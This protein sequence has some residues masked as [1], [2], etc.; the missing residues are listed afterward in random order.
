[1]PTTGT[2]GP[3]VARVDHFGMSVPDVDAAARFFETWF[4]ATVAFR[5]PWIEG[6]EAV[7]RLGVEGDAAFTLTM[8][9]L[10]GGRL[11][12]LQWNSPASGGEPPP[13]D[14]AGGVHIAIEVDDVASTVKRL[15]SAPGVRILSEAMTFADGPTA[16][17]TNA[18]LRTP[19]GGL[20]E[21]V[22]WDPPTPDEVETT[23]GGARVE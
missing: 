22:C 16:G 14:A 7:R 11:E 13:P 17:L 1:M 10:G 15:R 8:M 5:L 9:N 4:G 21:L 18:F 3:R 19:W 6:V 2:E 12:L 20:I 23:G